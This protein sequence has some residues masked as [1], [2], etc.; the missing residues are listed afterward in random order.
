MQSRLQTLNHVSFPETGGSSGEYGMEVDT[1]S[2]RKFI[3]LGLLSSASFNDPG[4]VGIGAPLWAF[5][6][7]FCFSAMYDV[8]RHP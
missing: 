2:F 6:A 4:I 7:T 3:H 1:K 5:T 8:V